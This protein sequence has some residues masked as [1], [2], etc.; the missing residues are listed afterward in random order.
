MSW[1]VRHL[2]HEELYKWYQEQPQPKCKRANFVARVM[3]YWYDK[4]TALHINSLHSEKTLRR[5]N[6]QIWEDGRVC[7]KCGEYKL[8]NEFARNKVW[9]K[10]YTS[11][12]KICR[13][14]AHAEYRLNWWYEKDREYKHRKRYLDTW[15]QI[16]FNSEI[17]EVGDYK[18]NKWYSVKSIVNWDE[19]RIS[20][21]DNHY[22]RNN[23]CVRFTKLETPVELV[24]PKKD[25]TPTIDIELEP[26]KEEK[27][28][29][30]DLDEMLYWEY[31]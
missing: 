13:N 10:G 2:K 17:R 27:K 26:P 28:F 11:I 29:S 31:E 21:S 3:R 7:R 8:R 30:I 1:W 5:Y 19:R 18:Y 14:K 6:S 22:R 20:T 23:N 12:C 9:V 16:Y 15:D 4:E 25:N 24:Q